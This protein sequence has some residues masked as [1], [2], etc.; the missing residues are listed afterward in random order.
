MHD[1]THF[2]MDKVKQWILKNNTSINPDDLSDDL[3]LIEHRVIDSL[4]FVEFILFLETVVGEE[5]YTKD[6]ELNRIRSLQSIEK[7]Y[8]Q[9]ES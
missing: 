6:F 7:Y 1:V 5:V 9:K 2:K 3:D 4:Q 8:F